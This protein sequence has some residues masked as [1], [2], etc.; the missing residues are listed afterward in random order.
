MTAR[1]PHL[2]SRTRKSERTEYP[3]F[4]FSGTTLTVSMCR[5]EFSKVLRDV[6]DGTT[7]QNSTK[8]TLAL[9]TQK[10]LLDRYPNSFANCLNVV[11]W[12]GKEKLCEIKP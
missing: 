11:S 10:A 7:W 8:D 2:D 9:H 5:G 4:S 3:L 12:S 6:Y 1:V